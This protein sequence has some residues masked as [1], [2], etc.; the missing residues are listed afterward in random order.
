MY[1]Q[2]ATVDHRQPISMHACKRVKDPFT[3]KLKKYI[4]PALRRRNVLSDLVRIGGIIIFH[5][6][7]LWKTL[8]DVI[9]LVRLPRKFEIDLTLGS[10]AAGMMFDS[11][12]RVSGV[13]SQDHRAM[14]CNVM[15]GDASN[16]IK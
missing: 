2:P 5:L 4:L 12:S 6:S 14:A 16:I 7:K 15:Q 8:C 9:I 1:M 13:W 3:P 10:D 11:Y